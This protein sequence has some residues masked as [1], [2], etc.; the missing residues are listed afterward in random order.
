MDSG[1]PE[2][3]QKT[4]G[5][6]RR[7]F[8]NHDTQ[9]EEAILLPG[10][11]SSLHRHLTKS[12][13]FI[14]TEQGTLTITEYGTGEHPTAKPT[15]HVSIGMD[16]DLLEHTVMP[17]VWH[18]MNARTFVR[19]YEIYHKMD[20]GS[21]TPLDPDEIDRHDTNRMNDEA[22]IAYYRGTRAIWRCQ[23]CHNSQDA[24]R[25]AVLIEN[26]Q[27]VL[28]CQDCITTTDHIK[29]RGDAW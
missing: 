29:A 7:L 3:R 10:G 5:E 22:C 1:L 11:T 15:R 9:F 2:A 18:K 16:S 23:R 6:T 26:R 28:I 25:E 27:P 17:F 13:T 4:W 21:D 24:G 12:N 8:T 20:G 19:V 14:V